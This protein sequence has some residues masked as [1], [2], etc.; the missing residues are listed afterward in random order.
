MEALR[1][2]F[3]DRAGEDLAAMSHASACGDLGLLGE[4]CH[5]L[6]GVAA[7]FGYPEVGNAAKFLEDL[8]EQSAPPK[9]ISAAARQLFALLGRASAGAR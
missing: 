2:R 9:D 6:A 5:R 7:T 4:R 8:I 3:Q 1:A